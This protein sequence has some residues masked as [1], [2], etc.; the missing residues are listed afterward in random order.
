[1]HTEPFAKA[2]R[3]S[4]RNERCGGGAEVEIGDRSR[5]VVEGAEGGGHRQVIEV[6]GGV[7]VTDEIGERDG[8]FLILFDVE[9]NGDEIRA[10]G[11]RT[12]AV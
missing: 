4:H 1:M 5:T 9:G 11:Y 3:K 6:D 8:E 2:E 12:I 10:L 7:A